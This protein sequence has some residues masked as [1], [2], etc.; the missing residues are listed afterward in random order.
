MK[1]AVLIAVA[2]AALLCT[3]PV[4][5]QGPP[6]PGGFGGMRGAMGG[7]MACPA[8]ATMPPTARMIDRVADTLQ[9]TQDQA[10][11]LKAAMTKCE[12]TTLSLSQK[13]ADATKA[14]R[15]ALL[16]PTYDAQKVKDLAAAAE[17][18]EAA[19]VSARIDEWTQIRS[20]LTA[21][22]VKKLQEAM[23]VPRGGQRPVGRQRP[24]APPPGPD[25]AP[26]PPPPGE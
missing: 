26:P 1:T 12:E 10:T 15:D 2:L 5:S 9:L 7:G 3:A 20:I 4:W 25:E 21:D 16:A 23:A 14:L 24:G 19:L 17:K 11:K 22:Q 13:A 18:A 6:A 8:I